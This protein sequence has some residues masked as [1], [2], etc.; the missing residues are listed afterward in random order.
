VGG[1]T[2]GHDLVAENKIFEQ[3][4]TARMG[5]E[6]VLIIRKGDALIRRLGRMIAPSNYT[7]GRAMRGR[8]FV[9]V[10]FES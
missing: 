1:F 2:A 6:R 8:Q 7:E 10:H 5:L 4:R 3:R 9:A